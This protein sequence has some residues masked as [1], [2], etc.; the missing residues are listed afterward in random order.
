[1]PIFDSGYP[2]NTS[3]DDTDV[4]LTT[5]TSDSSA[6]KGVTLGSVWSWITSK[7]DWI[8]A[9]MLKADSVDT[10]AI[11]DDA[12]TPVK[13]SGGYKVGVIP[14]STFTSNG[15]KSITGVGFKPKYVEFEIMP[16]SS[17]SGAA[18]ISSG[19][20][21]EGG[22]QGWTAYAISGSNQS[23]NSATT[24][25][26]AMLTSATS[27]AVSLGF[28]YQSMNADGFSINVVASTAQFDVQYKAFA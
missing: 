14:A 22:N 16:T 3:P 10:D 27:A 28:T 19:S 25:A 17:T 24:G 2:K 21:D 15:V 13:R 12:V 1:M 26:F 6:V 5:D 18:F 9:A 23:R 8:T 7:T 11:E 20:M 4:V